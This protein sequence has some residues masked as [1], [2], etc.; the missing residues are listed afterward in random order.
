MN[1]K[2]NNDNMMNLIKRRKIKLVLWK[3]DVSQLAWL[4]LQAGFTYKQKRARTLCVRAVVRSPLL[5]REAVA[6]HTMFKL[7]Q[8]RVE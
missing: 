7:V 6:S 5:T 8:K 1:F 2:Q 3:V 4:E